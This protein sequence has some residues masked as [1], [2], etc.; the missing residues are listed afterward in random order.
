M[1]TIWYCG[2][3]DSRIVE[4]K[5]VEYILALGVKRAIVRLESGWQLADHPSL[6][7]SVNAILD[8]C[9]KRNPSARTA[10][11]AAR[12]ALNALDALDA[13]DARDALDARDARDAR[14]ALDALDARDARAARDALLSGLQRFAAW[15]IQCN[16]WWWRWD[17]SW[18]TATAFGARQIDKPTV[19]VWGEPL[20]EAY[21]AGAWLLYWTDDT[22]YWVAKPTVHKDVGIRRLHHS[23]GPALESDVENLYF[24]HGVL[25]PAFV[26]VRPDW[27]TVKHIDSE[28]NAEVRRVMLERYGWERYITDCGAKPVHKDAYG[29]LYRREL[30]NDEPIVMVRVMNSTPEPD[31][32]VKPYMLRVPPDI[33]T[34]HAAVAWTFGLKAREYRPAIE[35]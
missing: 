12:A 34:A 11:L 10:A 4:I 18:I 21:V 26:V 3:C 32:S 8:D 35:T 31:G 17:L 25:V 5:V 14:D 7:R 24:W 20:L 13:R 28:D 23:S 30:P 19:S 6:D 15:C 29:E 9:V 16:G 27:I 33:R 1:R 22:L 2:V